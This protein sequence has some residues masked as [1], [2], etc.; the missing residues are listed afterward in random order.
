MIV[1]RAIR[2]CVKRTERLANSAPIIKAAVIGYRPVDHRCHQKQITITTTKACVESVIPGI[3][4]FEVAY[5]MVDL[6]YPCIST[7]LNPFTM[8]VPYICVLCRAENRI[9]SYT[10]PA[11]NC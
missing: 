5:I 9:F 8:F 1:H 4:G 11:F 2:R 7:L 6:S 3:I 10:A